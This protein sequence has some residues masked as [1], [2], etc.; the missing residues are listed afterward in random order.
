M[1]TSQRARVLGALASLL[2]LLRK[3]WAV[4]VFMLSLAGVVVQSIHTYFLSDVVEV[5]GGQAM[6]MPLVIMAIG[7]YLIWYSMQA[8][9]KGWIS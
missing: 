9:K 2:L 1:Q 5:M 4:P 8:Q 3:A 6:F 7:A